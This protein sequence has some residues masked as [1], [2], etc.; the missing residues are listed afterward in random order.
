MKRRT[1]KKALKKAFAGR[2]MRGGD[3]SVIR[4]ACR[5]GDKTGV[6]QGVLNNV[7][8]I[9]GE[10]PAAVVRLA[11]MAAE[12]ALT[13]AA[14]H[15]FTKAAELN[16]LHVERKRLK[17][18]IRKAVGDIADAFRRVG[19]Q[20]AVTVPELARLGTALQEVEQAWL[21]HTARVNEA[22]R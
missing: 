15:V 3:W 10:P 19:R 14:Y 21:Q 13:V 11:Q 5:H 18:R 22:T 20:G 1:V 6:F 17:E 8:P 16:R 7:S 4:Y 12:E 2:G 9:T